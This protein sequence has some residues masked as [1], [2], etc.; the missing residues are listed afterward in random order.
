MKPT[1]LSGVIQK[2]YAK[3]IYESS[4]ENDNPVLLDFQ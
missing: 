1:E 2:E 4:H 3:M